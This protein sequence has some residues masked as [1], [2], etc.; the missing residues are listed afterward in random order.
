MRKYHIC[1]MTLCKGLRSEAV[2]TYRLNFEQATESC[3]NVWYIEGSEPKILVDA[4]ATAE[5]AAMHSLQ[6]QT[7]PLEDVQSLED[8]LAKVGLKPTDIEIVILTQLHWDHIGLAYKFTNAEFIVQK[9]ELDFARNPHPA[10]AMTGDYDN[11]IFNDLKLKVIEGDMEIID[12]VRV[13]FTPGHYPGG[14]SVAVDTPKGVAIITGFCSTLAN[15]EPP[16]RLR[17]KGFPVITPGLHIDICQAY[18]S[19]L[20]VKEAADIIL[21]LHECSF[22]NKARIP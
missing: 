17:N 10:S 5:M 14:Q 21:P 6:G 7:Q 22:I 20:R 11:K 9:A 16:Q 12:G 4:G 2:W 19:V 15:F 18:D 8:G 3:F 13:L 1:P